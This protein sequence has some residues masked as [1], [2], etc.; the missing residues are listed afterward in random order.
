VSGSFDGAGVAAAPVD[1]E[2]ETLRE[3]GKRLLG[4]VGAVASEAMGKATAALQEAAEKVQ[5]ERQGRRGRGGETVVVGAMVDEQD[6]TERTA[7]AEKKRPPERRRG[8]AAVLG[9]FWILIIG[10]LCMLSAAI[11]TGTWSVYRF[12]WPIEILLLAWALSAVMHITSSIWLF[13]PAGLVF[14]TGMLLVYSQWTGNWE[15][16]GILW[17]FEVWIA[18]ISIGLPILLHKY[19]HLSRFLARLLALLMSLA[20]IAMILVIGLRVGLDGLLLDLIGKIVP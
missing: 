15:A 7:T 13:I 10:N 9:A 11:P 4:A 20:S 2:M 8:G 16:W 18:A 19:R 1:D 17:L 5:D 12:G 3:A 6:E 14:G